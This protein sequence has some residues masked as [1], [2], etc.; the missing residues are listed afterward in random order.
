MRIF[1]FT[2]FNDQRHGRH[3]RRSSSWLQQ[4]VLVDEVLD[5]NLASNNTRE[6]RR[7]VAMRTI[8]HVPP[9]TQEDR[10]VP[11]RSHV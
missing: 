3:Q 6:K 8:S 9:A 1:R 7:E 5:V 4:H 2:G 11:C 10:A